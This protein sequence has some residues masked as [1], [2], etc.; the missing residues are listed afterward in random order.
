MGG[1]GGHMAHLHEDI[2]LTFGEIKDILST[3]ASANIEVTEKVDGYNL[4]LTVL[5]TGEIR[6]FR[7]AGDVKRGGMTPQEYA[8]KWKGHPAEVGFMRGFSAISQ[9]VK[10]LGEKLSQ[11]LKMDPDTLTWKLCIIILKPEEIQIL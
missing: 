10:G 8:D 3:V 9:A 4:F 2:D 6:T 5:P 11:F 1:L 7:N